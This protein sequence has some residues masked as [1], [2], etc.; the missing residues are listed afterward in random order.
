MTGMINEAACSDCGGSG[1]VTVLV[2][3]TRSGAGVS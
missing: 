2:G 3:D 1:E